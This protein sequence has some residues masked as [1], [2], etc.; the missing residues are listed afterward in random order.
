M[1]TYSNVLMYDI[2]CIWN[3]W[4]LFT[5]FQL[6]CIYTYFTI[7]LTLCRWFGYWDIKS[8]TQLNKLQYHIYVCQGVIF[9]V[10]SIKLINNLINTLCWLNHSFLIKLH[11]NNKYGLITQP[12]KYL[13]PIINTQWHRSSLALNGVI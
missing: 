12:Y 13:M 5:G 8:L 9:L 10:F 1:G 6:G 3:K 2:K 4:Q 7:P 11:V